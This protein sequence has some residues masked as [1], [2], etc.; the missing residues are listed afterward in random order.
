MTQGPS[1]QPEREEAEILYR[2]HLRTTAAVAAQT[3]SESAETVAKMAAALIATLRA[4]GKVMLCGNG[5]SAAQA[6]HL[7][8]EL[9]GRYL[10]ERRPL[11][12]ISLATD[13]STLTAIANDYRFDEIFSHQIEALAVDGDVLIALS[14]SGTSADVVM[15]AQTARAKNVT[16]LALTGQSGGELVKHADLALLVPSVTTPII[17][18]IHLAVG[19]VLCDLI[20]RALVAAPETFGVARK[21]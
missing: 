14:T 3:A 20:E 9:V 6:Q 17:Q 11:P 10:R 2:E 1:G 21:I 8:A 7:A 19:H 13:T 12:A 16:V 5:G 18:E 15:A 4:G